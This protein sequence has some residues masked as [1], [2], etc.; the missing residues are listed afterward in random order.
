MDSVFISSIGV[1][2]MGVHLLCLLLLG[3]ES[4]LR[5]FEGVIRYVYKVLD[6]FILFLFEL[7][8][9]WMYIESS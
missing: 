3:S 8:G 5:N 1:C 7:C 2:R 6:L 4:K 9:V